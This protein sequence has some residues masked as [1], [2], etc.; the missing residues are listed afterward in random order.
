MMD[1][2]IRSIAILGG[3]VI[4][5]MAAAA[6]SRVLKS[7]YCRIYLIESPRISVTPA[8][9]AT[10][11]AF[12]HFHQLLGIDESEFLAQTQ[13]TFK[14][15]I[16][17]KDW[18]R[19]GRS[20]FHAFGAFGA[21]I[22]GVAF[23]HHWL[24]LRQ[25]GSTTSIEEYSMATVAA[26]LARFT[27]P[28]NDNLSVLSL[29]SYAYH[30]DTAKYAQYLSAYAQARGVVRHGRELAHVKL[31]G[32][33]GFIEA[34]ALDDGSELKADFFIDCSNDR[35]HLIEHG[36][37]TGY[38]DWSRWLPC[39]RAVTAACVRNSD[40]APYTQSFA[41]PAGWRWR[42][43]LQNAVD[44]GV[45]YCS[46]LSSDDEAASFLLDNLEGEALAEPQFLRFTPGRPKQ[47][48][49]KNCLT[50]AGGY[51]EPLEST[52]FHLVQTGITRLLTVFPDRSF[53]RSDM[54]EYNRLTIMEHER[55]RDFLILH[56]STTQRDDTPFWIHCRNMEIPDT[57]RQKL[58]LF[59][60]CG[61]VSM[62]PTE[63]FGEESWLSILFGHEIW[64]RRYDP[65]TDL[66]DEEELKRSLA[67]MEA[68]I[69]LGADSMPVHRQF[70]ANKR[71]ASPGSM[72]HSQIGPDIRGVP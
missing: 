2:H 64:P 8:G 61:R 19:L 34:L 45:V 4:G 20:Y 48:W 14:L 11:P 30:F 62:L 58:E 24:K 27:H 66:F 49:N 23:H 28:L 3:G 32:A 15:G 37:K 60:S 16:E 5:W 26:K 25:L 29:F 56:Y 1:N 68:S 47:F 13:G 57:L 12:L 18:C 69:R 22:G 44:N 46:T 39:D 38:E 50:L 6:L 17:F 67:Q 54:D 40:L 10:V 72:G 33:D 9:E 65:L 51:A 59:R 70:V 63:H 36:L 42:I 55:I 53:N 41:L 35:G 43:R 71:L 21:K 52:C 7:D 31:R